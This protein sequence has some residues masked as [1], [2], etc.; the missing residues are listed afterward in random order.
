MKNIPGAVKRSGGPKTKRGKTA[1]S[2]NA[3][4]SGVYSRVA[5]LEDETIEELEQLREAI[6]SIFNHKP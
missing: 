6:F 4:R 5:L 2:K 1:S 3:V